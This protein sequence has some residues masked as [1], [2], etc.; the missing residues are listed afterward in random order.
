MNNLTSRKQR[1]LD[2]LII[3]YV[4]NKTPVGSD[5]LKNFKNLGISSATIRNY[6]TSLSKEGLLEKKHNSSGSI[7]TKRALKSYWKSNLGNLQIKNIDREMIK[8]T[9]L[10][11]FALVK[12]NCANKLVEVLKS[13]EYIILQFEN[14][15]IIIKFS[16]PIYR[17]AL[18][19]I[20]LDIAQIINI[21]TAVN[22][23]SLREK[24]VPL[25]NSGLEIAFLPYLA[26]LLSSREHLLKTINGSILDELS[27][28]LH[29]LDD[30]HLMFIITID[31]TQ[32][33]LLYGGLE[34]D[35]Q[36]FLQSITINLTK[37]E[38]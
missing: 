15:E 38:K 6:F 8:K 36:G 10:G 5:T 31:N 33:L 30:D 19:L 13:E 9:D 14:G 25:N 2:T 20:G 37:E 24:L 21:T 27:D 11:I 28:G 4:K 7:P 12:N 1:L 16:D 3:Y 34:C 29:F 18:E 23:K 17:L 35:F 32:K 22:A 26:P